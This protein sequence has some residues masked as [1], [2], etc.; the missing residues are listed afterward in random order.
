MIFVCGTANVCAAFVLLSRSLTESHGDTRYIR[1]KWIRQL[2]QLGY[3]YG[4]VLQQAW[5]YGVWYPA[6]KCPPCSGYPRPSKPKGFFDSPWWSIRFPERLRS[7]FRSRVHRQPLSLCGLSM[8][9]KVRI[10]GTLFWGSSIRDWTV[11]C[12]SNTRTERNGVSL[13]TNVTNEFVSFLPGNV[14]VAP[15]SQRL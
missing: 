11:V 5:V 7:R 15:R 10:E 14:T 2:I 13:K 9:Y 6:K 4:P 1:Q 3:E 12:V 8:W